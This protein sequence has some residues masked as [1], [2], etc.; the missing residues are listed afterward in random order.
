MRISDWSSDVCSSDL[1]PYRFPP[2]LGDVDV[3]LMAEGTHRRLYERLGAQLEARSGVAGTSFA[4]W[5]PN[6]SRV[7]V[8]G[9]FNHWDG[10]RHPL[11]KRHDIG[12]WEIFIP[13]V[14]RDAL[15]P[16]SEENTY[17]IT[18]L[19]R[20]SHTVFSSEKTNSKRKCR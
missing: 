14:G 12:V 4:V 1:D 15:S 3:Y 5:A 9:D 16:S 7:S 8:I 13:G 11:R 10:R 18:S 17:D 20:T 2:V 6:A 19:M